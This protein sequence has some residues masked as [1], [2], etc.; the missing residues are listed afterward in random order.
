M[1]ISAV[2]P[3]WN[4]RN[5]LAKLLETLA[6][7]TLPCFE[8]I[9]V[10]N[11]SEDG[12]GDL[13]ESKGARVLRF[14]ENRGF[15]AA[16][17]RGIA[18]SGGDA[19]A[20]LNSDVELRDSWI[21]ILSNIL[22]DQSD[23][24]FAVGKTLSSRD[25]SRIDGSWDL[26]SRAGLPWRA[27]FGF[28]A[29]CSAFNR[30]RPIAIAPF[31]AILLRRELWTRIGPLDERF[32]SYLEDVDYGIRCATGGFAGHYEPGAVCIH[33]GSATLGRWNSQSV[34]RMA[35]NQVFLVRKH[36]NP[37]PW[38]HL[39][40]GQGL[41]AFVA[42]R[43]GVFGPWIRGKSDGLLRKNSLEKSRHLSR[44]F[45]AEQENELLSLQAEL[46]WD[47]YWR[48]YALL[49]GWKAVAK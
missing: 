23:V 33:Q 25:L 30:S 45:F 9:V 22:S 40:V 4:G 11:G 39:I 19:V 20:I 3:V 31:T 26:I 2:I 44:V 35:R 28:S 14:P 10:D 32:E 18:A 17:N 21:Q 47:R 48:W 8:V 13:A 49:T 1:R 42:L 27:G 24:W 16:V 5:S 6:A 29:D 12:V 34:R 15:A 41:W 36:V 7:Q 43:N 46:G 37:I 38:W